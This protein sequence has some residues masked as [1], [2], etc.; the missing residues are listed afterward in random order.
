M[1]NTDTIIS[2]DVETTGMIPGYHSI[3]SLGAV[4]WRDG[5]EISTFY[6]CMKEW[7]GS[8]RDAST[9]NWWKTQHKD[10]WMA[11]RAEQKEPKEVMMGFYDW[12]HALPKERTLAAN[13]ACFDAALLWW[14]LHT[15]CGEDAITNLFKRHRAL[16]IRTY[17]AAVFDVPYSQ[18][19]RSILPPHW[20]EK[21]YITH[22][23]LD[24][25]RQQG[26]VLHH[27]MKANS[28]EDE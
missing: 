9:M 18:A 10:E 1:N 20:A 16:D 21:Q 2:F 11:I 15:F 14:Y 17:I 19:E 6:G 26:T 13:P 5:K 24:D 27:L 22:N 23:A 8:T 25:A 3:I 4:A 7:Y 12:C 28:G